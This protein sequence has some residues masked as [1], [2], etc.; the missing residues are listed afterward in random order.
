[1]LESGLQ[2]DARDPA[3]VD[4]ITVTF[5]TTQNRSSI[6][7]LHRVRVM[8]WSECQYRLVCETAAFE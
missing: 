1:M 4:D 6:R 8:I 3:I 2:A 5:L 7:P